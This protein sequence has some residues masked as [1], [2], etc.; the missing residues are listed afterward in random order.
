MVDLHGAAQVKS[1][2]SFSSSQDSSN[3]GHVYLILQGLDEHHYTIV[4]EFHLR[5]NTEKPTFFNVVG[6]GI[7][8]IHDSSPW[9]LKEKQS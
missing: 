8:K 9:M 3:E 1:V 6:T 2:T 4:K 7:I 5:L